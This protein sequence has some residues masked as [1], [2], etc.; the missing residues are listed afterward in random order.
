MKK[1][2]INDYKNTTEGNKLFSL[3]YNNFCNNCFSI[4]L[5]INS[6]FTLFLFFQ[7]RKLN[8]LLNK[9]Y[10]ELSDISNFKKNETFLEKHL[11]ISYK[12]GKMKNHRLDIDM[13]GLKYPEILFEKIKSDIQNGEIISSLCEF[14]TQL[15]EKLIFLEKEINVTKLHAFY[16]ARKN[17]LQK[18]NIYYDDS[19][20]KEF[21]NIMSW[22]VIHKSTQLKGIASDK[23]LGCKY[24]EMKIGK[25][26]CQ[27]RIAVYN[28]VEE[29]DFENLIKTGNLI[30]KISNGCH[31]SVY[32]KKNNSENYIK[33][34][35]KK[36]TYFFNRD[37][38]FI[39]PEFFHDYSKKRIVLEKLFSP[40]EDLNEF[41]YMIFNNEIK[42]IYLVQQKNGKEINYYFDKNYKPIE[43]YGKISNINLF[44]SFDKNQLDEMTFL[45]LKLS[46][47]FKNFIR[48]DL[49][50]FHNNIY[51]SELTFDSH[52]GKP[53]FNGIKYFREG[54]KN[55]KRFE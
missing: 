53:T 7:N 41:K 50:L 52:S 2:N 25:N 21:H 43:E 9:Q 30:L 37:Y 15:E 34:I 19:K 49:Y 36:V 20:I 35:K 16:T 48:V 4:F 23:Y 8:S 10:I 44:N 47:D 3:Y 11:N 39:I 51:L 55:W 17:Y 5:L 26:L 1:I 13:I 28:N 38:S 29:I 18:N 40:I 54:L 45:A 46:E 27:Q 24:A 6:L 42:M 12:I 32:I 31:D 22:L 14:L 33:E